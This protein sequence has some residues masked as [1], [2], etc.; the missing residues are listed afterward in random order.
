[1]P[2]L[3]AR[4]NPLNDDFIARERRRRQSAPVIVTAPNVTDEKRSATPPCTK[5]QSARA[6]RRHRPRTG[7]AHLSTKEPFAAPLPGSV[8]ALATTVQIPRKQFK[9][10]KKIFDEHDADNDGV[11]TLDEFVAAVAKADVRKAEQEGDRV[12]AKFFDEV[13]GDTIGEMAER[14]Y[15]KGAHAQRRHAAGMFQAIMRKKT[16]SC[17][18]QVLSLLDFLVLYFPHLPRSAV[19]RAYD[20]YTKPPPPPPKRKTLG[21]VDGAKEEIAQMFRGLD[22]DQDGL[23]RMRS[24][25]PLMSQLGIS[26]QDTDDWLAEL[27]PPLHRAQAGLNALKDPQMSRKKSKLTIQDLECLLEPVFVQSPKKMTKEDIAKQ[28]ELNHDIAM[29]VMYG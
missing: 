5:P 9:L 7:D 24:L 18:T 21:D 11:L 16:A 22:R 17:S 1:M 12:K 6:P 23:V 28:I 2:P 13:V 25:K 26:E 29:D 14:S 19:K 20:K 8:K 15:L 3:K 27:P 10:I 4:Y